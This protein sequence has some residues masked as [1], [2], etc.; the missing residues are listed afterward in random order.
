MAKHPPE[1]FMLKILSPDK[2]YYE[3]E[4]VSISAANV[5]GPFDVLAKHTNFFSLLTPGNIVI[6]T[7]TDNLTIPINSGIIKVVSHQATIFVNI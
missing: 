2:K 1:T 7:P 5:D 3:G 6:V 4:A